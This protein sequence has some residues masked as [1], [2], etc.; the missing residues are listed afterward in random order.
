MAEPKSPTPSG[1]N[2]DDT[3][4]RSIAGQI[5]GMLDDDGHYNPGGKQSRAL[6]PD[7]YEEGSEPK[8][9]ERDE[10][11]RFRKAADQA[12][13]EMPDAEVEGDLEAAGDVEYEDTEADVEYTEDGDTDEQL[14]DSAVEEPESESTETGEPIRTVAELSEALGMTREEFLES[15]TDTFGAAGD[16]VT[17]TLADQIKGY[18]KDADYRRSTQQLAEQ[19]QQ[20]EQ[21]YQTQMQLF[22]QNHQLLASHLNATEQIVAAKLE[23]P[24]LLRLR[25][26]DPAEWTARNTEIA[27]DL[28]AIRQSRTQAAQQYMHQRS[29]FDTQLKERETQALLQVIPDFGETHKATT[30]DLMKSIGYSDDEIKNVFDHR[31]V[32]AALELSA[33]R[34]ENA[35]LRSEKERATD[36]VKRVKKDVPRLQKPGKQRLATP[37]GIQRSNLARLQ[38]RA[39]QTGSV[40]D[41]AAVIEQLMQ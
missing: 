12:D 41:A 18:Q 11:G 17:V 4:L 26:T 16:E 5:E 38:K 39:A 27:R 33:L 19:R 34:E 25:D 8:S 29:Q 37:Q 13:E 23:D 3:N 36:A 14:A 20:A 10:R 1:G 32:V 21:Q 22:E 30:R 6:D 31:L 7:G 9:T 15:I 24:N 2:P 35:Q 40:N 28:E